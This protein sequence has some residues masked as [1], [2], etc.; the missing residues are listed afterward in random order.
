MN[1]SQPR[2]LSYALEAVARENVRLTP[3]ATLLLLVAIDAIDD[4][5]S[6][7][8]AERNIKLEDLQSQ[9][10]NR[11]PKIVPAIA[12]H[13]KTP[14]V[15]GLMMLNVMPRI[16]SGFCLPFESPPASAAGE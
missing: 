2:N 3:G 8:A 11:V 15:D 9:I 14:V 6:G 1:N 5:L 10:I 13:Y 7:R 4:D 16:M 12:R